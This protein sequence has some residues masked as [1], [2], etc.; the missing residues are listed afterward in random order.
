[1][2]DKEKLNIA[3]CNIVTDSEICQHCELNHHFEND[4]A[5]YCFFAVDCII[6]DHK[7]YMEAY[8]E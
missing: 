3:L 4:R 5:S 7:D 6:N 8:K 1:M 2:T